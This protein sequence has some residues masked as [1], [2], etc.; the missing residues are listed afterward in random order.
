[1]KDNLH[2]FRLEYCDSGNVTERVERDGPLPIET[3]M[4]FAFQ[5]LDALHYAH[6]VKLSVPDP[7]NGGQV[8]D[9]HGVVHHDI[10]PDNLF[11][12]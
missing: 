4:P 1:M 12:S 2:Y 3:A 10:K 6:T 8:L 5:M 7:D 9:V 11:L